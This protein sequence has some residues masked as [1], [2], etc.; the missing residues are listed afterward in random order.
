MSVSRLIVGTNWF[1]GY[2]HCTPSQDTYIKENIR[3][4]KAMADIMEVFFRRGVDSVL[5][6]ITP[7]P[8]VDAIK[9]VQDRTGVKGVIISTPH[10]KIGPETPANGLDPD[11]VQRVLDDEARCGAHIC[12]PH[13]CITDALLDRC[14]RTIRHID[15]ITRG[16]RE[17]GMVPGLSTHMPETIIY[18]DESK[19]DIETY[20]SIYNSMGFL[21]QVE[22]DWTASIIQKAAKPVLTIKPMASGQVRP[23]QGMNFV[24]NTIR[25]QDMVAVGT[26][27]PR[28]AEE[29]IDMSLQILANQAGN[30]KLQETRSKASVKPK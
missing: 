25:P 14:S 9:D 18:T 5:G 22:V 12:M 7:E 8:M 19:I 1:M 17:R 23:F 16:I 13:Q 24:W 20:I 10:F 21:M 26:M 30:I 15:Q 11:D 2:S 29:L 27:C 4:R 3:Q 28:E 6:G